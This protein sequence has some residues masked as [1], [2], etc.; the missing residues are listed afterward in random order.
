[1]RVNWVFAAGSYFDPSIDIEQIKRIGATW[2]SWKTWRGCATDNV[3]CSDLPKIKELLARSF[4]KNCNFYIPEN[5]YADLG[6]PPN[7]NLYHG[8]YQQEV[9]DLEN[10]V[11]IHLALSNSDLVL[12]YGFD[13]TVSESVIDRFQQHKVTN[14]HGL[15]RS[16]IK[17]N[18][19]IQWVAV[20]HNQKLNK[21]YKEL[22]NLTCDEMKSVLKLL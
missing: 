9:D 12:L 2:G 18:L 16:A 22:P 15:I 10:I 6:R 11:A 17:S 14:Y 1:M 19:D 5:F 20:N 3:V 4:Q 8:N 13:L 21:A 7:V